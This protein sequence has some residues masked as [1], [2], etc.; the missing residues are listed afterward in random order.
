MVV[1]W[2]LV[3]ALNLLDDSMAGVVHGVL[4]GE[5]MGAGVVSRFAYSKEAT[6][7][8]RVCASLVV[9]SIFV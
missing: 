4:N 8:G 2:T 7:V 6:G 1:V 3:A 5:C 9:A